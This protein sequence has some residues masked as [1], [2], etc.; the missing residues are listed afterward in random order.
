[1]TFAIRMAVL[2][3]LAA[4]PAMAQLGPPGVPAKPFDQSAPPPAP[5]YRNPAHWAALPDRVDAADAVPMGDPFGDRQATAAVDAFY[6]HPTT[7]RGGEFWNQPLEDQATNRWTDE[8]VIGR[9]AAVFNACCRVY[10]PRYRQATAA[11]L[12]VP[13]Q[14]KGL[15]SHEFAWID[16]RA[17]FLH[18]LKHWNKGRPFIIAGHSQGGAHTER[19]MAEFARDPKLRA[20]FVAAYPIGIAFPLGQLE[21][22]SGGIGVC[23]TPLQTDCYVTWNTYGPSGD[24]TTLSNMARQRYQQRFGAQDSPPIVCVNPL[25][26]SAAR[27]EVAASGNFGALPS[28]RSDGSLPATEAGVLGAACVDGVVKVTAVPASGYAIVNLP[29]GFLHFNDFDLFYQNIRIN[30]VARTDAWLAQRRR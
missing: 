18:Y 2:V 24:G 19:W 11:S 7:Y 26:F 16:V 6:I 25:S 14:M 28:T 12:A 8:S 20:R 3:L 1:M 5:D 4:G 23:T 22:Q 10:A 9:Q 15:Q 13:P 17:A 21:R 30:A 29:G 27:A